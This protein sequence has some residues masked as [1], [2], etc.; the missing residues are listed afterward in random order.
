QQSNS[1][2]FIFSLVNQD[3]NGFEGWMDKKLIFKGLKS[4]HFH[5]HLALAICGFK[6]GGAYSSSRYLIGQVNRGK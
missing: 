5:K 2:F 6:K 1:M 3:L 4:S